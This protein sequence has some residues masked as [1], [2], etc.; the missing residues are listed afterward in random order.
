MNLQKTYTVSLMFISKVPFWRHS[1]AQE[2]TNFHVY[3]MPHGNTKRCSNAIT[4]SG[5]PNI[6]HAQTQTQRHSNKSQ[7]M[8][9]LCKQVSSN[10]KRE[11][12]KLDGSRSKSKE[13]NGICRV[14]NR[15][16]KIYELIQYL[17][18]EAISTHYMNIKAYILSQG[19]N[20]CA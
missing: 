8:W 10:A 14:M 4:F 13:Q 7:I 1:L 17:Q 18:R 12:K 19:V 16:R 5:W 9:K 2:H 11:K 15:S 3:F 6:W 20:C